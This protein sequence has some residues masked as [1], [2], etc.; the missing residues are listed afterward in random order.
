MNQ[1]AGADDTKTAKAD[2]F[3]L[4]TFARLR[5]ARR[6]AQVLVIGYLPLGFALF[7][8]NAPQLSGTIALALWLV[9][10]IAALLHL[11]AHDCPRCR[12]LFYAA[13]QWGATD[14]HIP[15]GRR[16]MHCGFTLGPLMSDHE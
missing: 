12:Q 8:L 14:L 4:A 10:A 13:S 7:F 6:L 5:R 2:G 15:F 9:V 16:C 1:M 3:D 11:R